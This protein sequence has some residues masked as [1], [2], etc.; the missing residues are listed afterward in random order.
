MIAKLIS[1]GER[2][3]YIPGI[4]TIGKFGK[5]VNISGRAEE[6]DMLGGM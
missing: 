4:L 5:Q 1:S 2:R 6:D 3:E